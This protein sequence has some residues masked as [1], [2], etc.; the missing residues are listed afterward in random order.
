MLPV[1][2]LPFSDGRL[3]LS[4]QPVIAFPAHVIAELK[5]KDNGGNISEADVHEDMV[6]PAL[7]EVGK[8][9]LP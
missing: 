9:V 6:P 3:A 4:A 2:Y 7:S 8:D 5:T 1:E